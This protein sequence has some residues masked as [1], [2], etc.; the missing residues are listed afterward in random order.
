M[1]GIRA[2]ELR[3]VLD[4]VGEVV[5]ISSAEK[6]LEHF[7]RGAMRLTHTDVLGIVA[8]SREGDIYKPGVGYVLGLDDAG[9]RTLYEWYI[10]GGAFRWD[11]FSKA[12]IRSGE[13]TARRRDVLSDSVWYSDPHLDGWKSIGLDETMASVRPLK[14]QGLGLLARREWG[15]RAYRKE[16]K[17]KL[18]LLSNTFLWLFQN[19][20]VDGY[21]GAPLEVPI[22]QQQV[23]QG[24]LRGYSEKEI[25]AQLVLS[26]RTVHK[27]VEHLLRHFG[28]HSRAKLMAMW[29]HSPRRSDSSNPVTT[30][31]GPFGYCLPR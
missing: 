22:R 4:L 8:L 28:V 9:T 25:A 20:E 26:P 24:L 16:D 6:R 12:M 31:F 1:K 13:T 21:F 14:T 29:I 3:K 23:L 11:P 7:L 27:Y 2:K 19:L 5:E 10:E 30:R 18:H 15:S 17:E